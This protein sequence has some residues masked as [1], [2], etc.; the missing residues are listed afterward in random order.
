MRSQAFPASSFLRFVK[1]A[2][3]TQARIGAAAAHTFCL[4]APLVGRIGYTPAQG[5]DTA[6]ASPGE[7]VG[8]V[9]GFPPDTYV[10]GQWLDTAITPAKTI[11]EIPFRTDSTDAQ[12]LSGPS[13]IAASDRI[14]EVVFSVG[15][16]DLEAR[17]QGPPAYPCAG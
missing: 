1:H 8:D 14:T 4:S 11:T 10:L 17:P 16:S 2:T 13:F 15:T 7:A 9:G 6:N 5:T 3:A 12:H